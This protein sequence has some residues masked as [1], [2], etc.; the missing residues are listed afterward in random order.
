MRVKGLAFSAYCLTVLIANQVLAAQAS[1]DPGRIQRQFEAPVVPHAAPDIAIPE[2]PKSIAPDEASKVKVTLTAILVDGSTVYSADSFQELTI[3]LTGHEIA[4]SEIFTLADAITTR[5]RNDDYILSRALVPAQKLDNGVLHIQVI[6]GFIEKVIFDGDPTAL[7]EQYGK[8]ISEER[9]LRG[10]VLERYLLLMN[11]IPG[12]SVK[13]VME[14]AKN[15]VGGSDLTLVVKQK[16]GDAYA[17]IDNRGTRYIGAVQAFSGVSVNN[18]FGRDDKASINYATVAH[19]REL[20]YV[21]IKEEIPLG[22]DGLI[23]AINGGRSFSRPGFLLE[24]LNAKTAGTMF[25]AKLTYP[26]KRSRADTLKISTAFDLLNSETTLNNEADV[27]PSSND[28]IRAFRFGLSYDWADSFY[29]HNIF[30]STISQGL[31]VFGASSNGNALLSR[32]GGR[33]DFEKLTMDMSRRQELD[34]WFQNISLYLAASAQHSLANPLLSSEQFGAGG[35]T[36]GRGYDPSEI[37]G[38]S[39]IATKAELQYSFSSDGIVRAWQ[40]YTFYDLA[41]V[42]NR[43]PDNKGDV[44]YSLASVGGGTRFDMLDALSGD[45]TL[46]QPLTRDIATETL[47]GRDGKP[48]KLLFSL[49]ARY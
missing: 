37:T 16:K 32:P 43:Q 49:T 5:Y 31:G 7:L 18:A 9:P 47:A 4:L 8:H 13:A 45:V 1:I 12:R 33:V 10:S 36:F 48:L 39:G 44:A 46:A 34:H 19:T 2:I 41:G 6:E 27:P 35:S 21:N 30:E 3:P 40:F 20:S 42:R 15:S 25:G 14:P 17:G 28:R 22:N 29:G 24:Q 11:D 38:D 26:V 23:L